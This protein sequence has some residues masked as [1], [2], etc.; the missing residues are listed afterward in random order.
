[1]ATTLTIDELER[2]ILYLREQNQKI[3]QELSKCIEENAALRE[4]LH[5]Q[6]D[7]LAEGYE[8]FGE[9]GGVSI[10]QKGSKPKRGF[11]VIRPS[12]N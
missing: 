8:D 4:K 5:V 1:M 9:E 11:I 2:E 7:S 6:V 3:L 12:L 10:E